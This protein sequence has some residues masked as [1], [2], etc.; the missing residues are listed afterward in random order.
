MFGESAGG[1]SIMFLLLDPEGRLVRARGEGG[2]IGVAG[3][4]VESAAY[5]PVYPP[6]RE[7][8][9]WDKFVDGIASCASG[10]NRTSVTAGVGEDLECARAASTEELY[11][12]ILTLPG[13]ETTSPFQPVLDTVSSDSLVPQRPSILL[14]NLR[15]NVPG[16]KKIPVM[17]GANLD[18]GTVFS[19]Q[20]IQSDGEIEKLVLGATSPPDVDPAV[21][22]EYVKGLV[23]VYPDEPA[24]NS[25]Y[26]TGNET[27][28]LSPFWKKYNSL[29]ESLFL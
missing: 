10:G 25:P 11:A 5:P 28:G 4:I 15:L 3:A 19:P 9:V 18:E 23:D 14:D 26:G 6:E 21:Q 7:Q 27:F 2:G 29:C 24:L 20:G 16:R 8:G 13:L 22:Q 1:T 17:I 12:S